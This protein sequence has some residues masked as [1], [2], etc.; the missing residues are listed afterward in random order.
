MVRTLVALIILMYRLIINRTVQAPNTAM[1][2]R[3]NAPRVYIM[4]VVPTPYFASL[5]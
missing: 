2:V 1:V 5:C 4:C 3:F